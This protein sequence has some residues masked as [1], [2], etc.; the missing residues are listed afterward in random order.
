MSGIFVPSNF[1]DDEPLHSSSIRLHNS[2]GNLINPVTGE[3]EWFHSSSTHGTTFSNDYLNSRSQFAGVYHVALYS[4]ALHSGYLHCNTIR[5]Q[6]PLV[7]LDHHD[8]FYNT[9]KDQTIGRGQFHDLPGLVHHYI[10]KYGAKVLPEYG[11]PNEEGAEERFYKEQNDR[12]TKIL[13]A[14]K[15]LC[16]SIIKERTSDPWHV[17][18]DCASC[19][20]LPPQPV[21]DTRK[22]SSDYVKNFTNTQRLHVLRSGLTLD[23]Y[24]GLMFHYGSRNPTIF[25]IDPERQIQVKRV[26][27]EDHY[28]GHNDGTSEWARFVAEQAGKIHEIPGL[29]QYILKNDLFEAERARGEGSRAR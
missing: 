2:E 7:L 25:A 11:D 23:G 8:S 4:N 28:G 17:P 3:D 1:F 9:E 16:D 20:Y 14:H 21:L 22:F 6:H 26:I 5:M 27:K 10:F 13:S 29:H 24:D 19:N 12:N 15:A 18:C